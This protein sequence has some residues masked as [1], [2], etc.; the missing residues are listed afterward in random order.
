MFMVSVKAKRKNIVLMI[1]L[2]LI[3]L[4][5]ILTA[6]LVHGSGSQTTMAGGKYSVKAE[7]NEDRVAFLKQFGWEVSP[8]PIE[9][10]EVTIPASFNDVYEKYNAIQKEQG[11]DLTRYAGKICKQWVYQVN[12]A[13]DQGSPVHATLLVYGGK[14]IGGDISSTPLDGYMCGFSGSERISPDNMAK[15]LPAESQAKEGKNLSE[16]PTNAWPVD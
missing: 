15:Q 9:I 8:E 1:L 2:I 6:V 16:I 10:R 4:L 5:V 13:M 12:N 7:T 3:L 14:V 11:L